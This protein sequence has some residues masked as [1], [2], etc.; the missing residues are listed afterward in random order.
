[1]VLFC[2][3]SCHYSALAILIRCS[4]EWL[5]LQIKSLKALYSSGVTFALHGNV[6]SHNLHLCTST[7]AFRLYTHIY[8]PCAYLLFTWT[9]VIYADGSLYDPTHIYFEKINPKTVRSLINYYIILL[10]P[11]TIMFISPYPMSV[12]YM[13]VRSVRKYLTSKWD[14]ILVRK[15]SF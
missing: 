5:K 1:M 8:L 2:N 6:A 10:N 11:I 4:I 7:T 14:P 12:I 13:A 15:N 3:S 9:L